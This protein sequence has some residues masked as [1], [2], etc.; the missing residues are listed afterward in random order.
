GVGARLRLQHLAGIFEDRAD[1]RAHALLVVDD[2][3]RPAAGQRGGLEHI[4][5]RH[6]WASRSSTR[7]WACPPLPGRCTH[8]STERPAGTAVTSASSLGISPTRTRS[9]CAARSR[10]TPT[11]TLWPGVTLA[12]RRC[13][14]GTSRILVPLSSMIT[15]PGRRPATSAGPPLTTSATSTPS[16]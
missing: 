2:H 4:G 1:G 15:S 14:S 10:T 16:R 11:A 3:D 7:Y 9:F 6:R 13:R 8:S 12:T 5:G